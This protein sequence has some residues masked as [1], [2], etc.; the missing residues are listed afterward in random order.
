MKTAKPWMHL[1]LGMDDEENAATLSNYDKELL[2]RKTIHV[3]STLK[4][5]ITS[6]SN[7]QQLTWMQACELACEEH[8]NVITVRTV[9]TWYRELHMGRPDSGLNSAAINKEKI[10]PL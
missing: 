6:V 1:L 2:K 7:N 8:L 10:Q 9:M 4:H 3:I 5:M